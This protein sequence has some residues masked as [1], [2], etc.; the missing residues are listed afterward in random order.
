MKVS[1][2][3]LRASAHELRVCAGQLAIAAEC[4]REASR[5]GLTEDSILALIGPGHEARAELLQR[6]LDKASTMLSNTARTLAE[7]ARNYDAGNLQA[8]RLLSSGVGS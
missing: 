2:E 4:H 5:W 1:T 8:V 7:A 6:R 3:V